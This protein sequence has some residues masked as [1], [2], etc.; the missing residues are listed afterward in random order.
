VKTYNI[1]NFFKNSFTKYDFL[2]K[3]IFG[4]SNILAN[5]LINVEVAKVP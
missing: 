3:V 1:S 2:K 4:I 5:N